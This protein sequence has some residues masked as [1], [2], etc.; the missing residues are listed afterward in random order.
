[1]LIRPLRLAEFEILYDTF[2]RSE[3]LPIRNTFFRSRRY[4]QLKDDHGLVDYM[5]KAGL[6]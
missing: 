6:M 1:M 5:K 3:D 4:P 2:S